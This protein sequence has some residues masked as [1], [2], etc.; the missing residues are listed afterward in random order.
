MEERNR[1]MEAA[2]LHIS[3]N[4]GTQ[5][6]SSS[7]AELELQSDVYRGSAGDVM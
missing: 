3:K 2:L 4:L 5:F 6:G 7:S 1:R